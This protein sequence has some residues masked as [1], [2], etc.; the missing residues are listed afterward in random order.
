MINII[1]G[2]N[3]GEIRKIDLFFRNRKQSIWFDDQLV[4]DMIMDVDRTIVVKGEVLESPIYGFVSPEILSGGVKTLI[5]MYKMR[6][7]I[8][9]GEAMGGNCAK[10]V[11]EI[12]KRVDCT[13]T[14]ENGFLIFGKGRRD[15]SPMDA[16]VVDTGVKI[17]TI[18][19]YYDQFDK[20]CV[21]YFKPLIEFEREKL[22]M[23]EL[24][25][26]EPDD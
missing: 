4:R 9:W 19:E 17:H 22:R 13:L 3:K 26:V 15:T 21:E 6:G 11:L 16:I 12:G 24:A 8:A 5:L 14:I 20:Y 2:S 25:Y 1:F 7:F 10:W 23:E 18:K